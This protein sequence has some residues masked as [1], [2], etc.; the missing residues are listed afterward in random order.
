MFDDCDNY[1]VAIIGSGPVGCT[2]ARKLIEANYKVVMLEAGS[3]ES[4]LPGLHL[5]SA[6]RYQRDI[7]SFNSV[8]RGHLHT[9]SVPTCEY[10]YPDTIDQT[11]ELKNGTLHLN[12]NPDQRGEDNLSAAAAVYSVGGMGTLWSC[13]TPRLRGKER[14]PDLIPNDEMDQLYDE[15]EAYVQTNC[16]P[17][18]GTMLQ[19]TVLEQLI[20]HYKFIGLP[21]ESDGPKPLPL[22]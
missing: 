12:Q 18:S 3:K 22:A 8:I 4:D 17:Y 2:F 6:F 19:T 13:I 20:K 14:F 7:N 15:A 11:A 10:V 16:D 21:D 1:D 9:L 5:R